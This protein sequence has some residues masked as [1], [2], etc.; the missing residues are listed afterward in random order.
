MFIRTRDSVKMVE[1][2]KEISFLNS[3]RKGNVVKKI[4]ISDGDVQF[5][6]DELLN[7]M[8]PK[9]DIQIFDNKEIKIIITANNDMLTYQDFKDMNCKFLILNDDEVTTIEFDEIVPDDTEILCYD[10]EI[11]DYY[12]AKVS[13]VLSL[14]Y[15][16]L[17][18]GEED[19]QVEEN[20]LTFKRELATLS[21]YI[22]YSEPYTGIILN[23]ILVM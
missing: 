4:K 3:N 21:N 8:I 18:D 1:G 17:L 15:E 23:N 10:L 2:T 22:L 20:N 7:R 5:F 16:H 6:D 14:Q 9:K 13:V 19:T 12:F 11:D